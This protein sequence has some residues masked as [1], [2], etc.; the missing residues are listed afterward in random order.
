MEL[1][2]TDEQA[3]NA[4]TLHKQSQEQAIEYLM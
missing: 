2:F 4:L 1:G 3:V